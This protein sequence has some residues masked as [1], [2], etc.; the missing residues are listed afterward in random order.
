MVGIHI[1][2]WVRGSS[3][4]VKVEPHERGMV[5]TCG[6]SVWVHD[7]IF[8]EGAST[9]SS[10]GSRMPCLVVQRRLSL[11][12]CSRLMYSL[13]YHPCLFPPCSHNGYPPSSNMPQLLWGTSRQYYHVDAGM[14]KIYY[15]PSQT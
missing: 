10:I 9:T 1:Q 13:H 6:V 14:P 11:Y 8:S 12:H 15:K 5:K 2:A 4:M 3:L 7:E